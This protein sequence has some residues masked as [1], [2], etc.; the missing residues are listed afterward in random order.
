M[1]P[2][3]VEDEFKEMK[4]Y[5]ETSNSC[6]ACHKGAIKCPHP[7]ANLQEKIKEL[8]RKRTMRPFAIIM[9]CFAIAQFSGMTSIR[10]YM[11]QIFKAYAMP[12]DANW[13]TVRTI[14]DI[15]LFKDL[16]IS[17][18][19][20]VVGVMGLLAN[21]VCMSV[22]KVFGK[23]R[24]YFVS[25]TGTALCCFSLGNFGFFFFYLNA[26]SS[27]KLILIGLYAYNVLPTGWSSFD[28]HET[29]Q[30][31]VGNENY[32]A[33]VM[34]FSLA[35]FTSVGVTPIPWILLSEVFPFK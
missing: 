9:F 7:P 25:L 28:K 18:H 29:S 14:V 34:F 33:M 1:S 10:P 13:A 15:R 30:L 2:K 11:V 12:I 31:V 24:L 32:V 17:L 21:I 20:V 6:V 16:N 35:F 26:Q 27:K 5:S 4:R 8:S 19:Q 22:V 3:A 23:R